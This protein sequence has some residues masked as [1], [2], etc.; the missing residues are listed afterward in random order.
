M[1]ESGWISVD[2]FLS[3]SRR[4]LAF[5]RRLSEALKA[6]GLDVWVDLD[7]IIP[8]SRWMDEIHANIADADAV[9]FVITPDSVISEVC[10]IELDYAIGL[11]KRVVPVVARETARDR[12]PTDLTELQWLSITEEA[13]FD[14]AVKQLVEVLG[15]DIERVHLHTRLLTQAADWERRDHERSL[16]LRGA[17]LK[18][19]E[20]WLADQSGRRPAA[21][22]AQLKLILASRRAAVRRQR[23]LGTAGLVLAAVMAVLAAFALFQRQA[24]VNQAGIATA[25]QLLAEADALRDRQ[26]DVSLLLG[27]LALGNAPDQVEEEARSGL[28]SNLARPHHIATQFTGHSGAVNDVAFNADGTALASAGWDGTVRMWDVG[29]SQALGQPLATPPRYAGGA[30]TR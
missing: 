3:Y 23:G 25:R 27:V 9:V 15:T 4:D 13:D 21:N 7:D 20:I 29:T 28:E 1:S 22:S 8:S 12:V 2:V 6:C 5:V 18:E 11:P 14:A 10:R 26:P 17:E 24:A 30:P 19:A 16:L